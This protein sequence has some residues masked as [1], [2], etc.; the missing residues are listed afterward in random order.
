VDSLAA[1]P[2]VAAGHADSV[3]ALSLALLDTLGGEPHVFEAVLD[4][5]SGFRLV[6]R[7]FAALRGNAGAAQALALMGCALEPAEEERA[8][9]VSGR[10]L[11]T[12]SG[13]SYDASR[14]EVR[15]RLQVLNQSSAPLP[16]PLT[17]VLEPRSHSVRLVDADGYTC[18]VFSPGAPYVTLPVGAALAPGAVIEHLLRF[19][20]PRQESFEIERRV[21]SGYSSAPK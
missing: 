16:G 10:A 21:F 14:R 9:D 8:W 2:E 13:L 1:E 4:P 20:N 11:V 3:G 7:A 12:I 5:A 17:V 15:C 19:E 6:N 18:N